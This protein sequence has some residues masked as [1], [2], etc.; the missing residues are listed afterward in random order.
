MHGKTRSV[1]KW[2]GLYVPNP[3][4]ARLGGLRGRRGWQLQEGARRSGKPIS[5]AVRADGGPRFGLLAR[6]SPG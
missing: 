5:L 3:G 2:A 1:T 4:A 6:E